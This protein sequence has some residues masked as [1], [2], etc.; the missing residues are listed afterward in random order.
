MYVC[1]L[2]TSRNALVSK[3]GMSYSLRNISKKPDLLRCGN[4]SNFKMQFK[5]YIVNALKC[6]AGFN[7][8][9]NKCALPHTLCVPW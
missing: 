8:H 6:K 9:Y 1:K 4:N 7:L 2:P 3:V 5:S